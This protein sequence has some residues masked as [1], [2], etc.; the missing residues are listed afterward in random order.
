[1]KNP[2]TLTALAVA[3]IVAVATFLIIRTRSE[4]SKAEPAAQTAVVDKKARAK[5]RIKEVVDRRR[6]DRPAAAKRAK[7]DRSAIERSPKLSPADRKLADAVQAALDENDFAGVQ[8]AAENAYKSA[9]PEVRRD[10]VDALAWFGEEAL[11]DLTVMIS[12]PDE[13]VAEAAL[14][15]WE[16]G[17]SQIEESSDRLRISFLTMSALNDAN[18]LDSIS[19]HFSNAATE[20]IDEPE[21]EKTQNQR[22]GEVVQ[23]LVDMITS[24]NGNVSNT[25][26][27]MYEE[28]TGNKWISVAEAEKYLANPDKYEEPDDEY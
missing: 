26:K 24:E 19:T 22:R 5:A 3:L 23:G 6:K 12:D 9:N 21:D 28:V 20:Y 13:E 25:G 27:E 15:G 17:L 8:L 18:S 11:P 1:M 16:Q 4:Q 10:A 2:K 14:D 7:K